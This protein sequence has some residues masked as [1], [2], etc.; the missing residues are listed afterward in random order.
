MIPF[1]DVVKKGDNFSTVDIADACNYAA[2]DALMTYKIYFKLLE[3]F[4]KSN[5]EHLLDIANRYEFK[6][7]NVLINMQNNGVKI[8]T[9]ILKNLKSTNQEYIQELTKKIHN[10][11][12]SEFNINSPKQ[13][14]VILF[15]TLG[16]PASK[17]GKT[18]YSTNEVVLS[19]L[20]DSH[21]I[22]P[23]ILEYR[24][25]YKLQSTY[26]D[27]LLTLAT[28]DDENKIYTSFLQTG[29]ATGRL[30]SKNPNL[31]NIPV[32]SSAGR[33]IRKAFIARD[34]YKLV[35]IDYSQ[36]E[37]RLLAHF[38]KDKALVDAFNQGLDIHS[39]TAVKIFGEEKAAEKRNIAKTI[40]FG[41]LYGM[42]SKKLADT[43]KITPKEAKVY[44]ESYFEAFTNVKEYMKS[45]E[46]FAVKNGYVETLIKRRRNFDFNS[47]NT[48]QRIAYLR[49]AVNTKFQGS[50]ADLIKLSMIKIFEK[51][52]NN[53]NL[54][55]ILQI[56]DELIFEVKD[57]MIDEI[58]KDLVEIMENIF[59][60]EI[61]L[62]V[63]VAIGN[64]WGELK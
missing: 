33:E 60:L 37:L 58:T 21:E 42:G 2:E 20:M 25:A 12:G 8:D 50:A 40:N 1:K 59:V 27:P 28:N 22:I 19:K 13:L 62:K 31:Q 46:D 57:E 7:I 61:P 43:L 14:G 63:S 26:I 30:S 6:F 34:G 24:E 36:I 45:I 39:Q 17:K 35:G 54:K 52:K 32:R 3:E 47:A 44:I 38:S 18:G 15:D 5:C 53:Q 4:K 48:M 9:N 16:L 55:M 23:A 56:H 11:A 41:L 49:E 64:S 10:L 51:Y 29:T